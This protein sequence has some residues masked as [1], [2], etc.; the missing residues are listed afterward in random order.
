M[1]ETF[2]RLSQDFAPM[3][4]VQGDALSAD[5][6]QLKSWVNNLPRANPKATASLLFTGL[7]KSMAVRLSGATRYVQ[8][9]EIREVTLDSIAWLERQF[10]GSTL[11]LVQDRFEQA[12]RT[13][14][15]HIALADGYRLACYELCSPSGSIPMFKTSQ[16]NTALARSVWHYQQSLYLNWKLYRAPPDLVWLGLHRVFQF[17]KEIS[18]ES[19]DIEDPFLKRD[20]QIQHIYFETCLVSLM[21]P[22]AFAQSGQEQIRVIAASFAPHSSCSIQKNSERAVKLPV[23]A[24]KPV[25]SDLPNN[26]VSFFSFPE[27]L[28]ALEN[29]EKGSAE[30]NVDITITKGK[31][32][33]LPHSIL[34]R[35]K[36][37]LGQ[38]PER[39]FE[40]Q[41]EPYLI[42]TIIGFSNL[43]YFVAGQ[44]DF[45]DYVQQLSQMSGQ[46]LS[47]AAD[48]VGIG[49]DLS[50]QKIINATVND[51]SFG[52]Y[53]V[54]WQPDPHLR[55]R[56]GEVIGLNIQNSEAE[57]DW[58]LAVIR[59]LR[60]KPDN[61][62]V[63]GL[64]LIARRC[65]AV[66]LRVYQNKQA[67]SLMRGIEADPLND[68][69]PRQF[70]MSG[71]LDG[72]KQYVEV[73]YSYEPNRIGLSRSSE[74]FNS[75]SESIAF[76]M[77]YS[78]LT[79]QVE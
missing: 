50:A 52:G 43:H 59:W 37:S 69:L 60:Y 12:Q 3:D 40:R 38:A 48:W 23:D 53:Q 10:T 65:H 33:T 31:Y 9:E 57:P 77:D 2:K 78:L 16:V 32:L 61:S 35:V 26:Q 22:L 30:E 24:D 47:M 14:Q 29:I 18:L 25:N 64:E 7:V 54:Q 8:L 39:S 67:G 44:L 63:A 34:L 13:I 4:E 1:S 49:S 6:G 11:P 72:Q 17:A 41:S 28:R 68:N 15:L 70:L 58:M 55:V 21:N 76:N 79:A 27:L 66:A 74:K 56:V 20:V 42:Q 71:R 75:K 19:K 73:I 46:S 51:H 5:K 36:S 62:V 45:N